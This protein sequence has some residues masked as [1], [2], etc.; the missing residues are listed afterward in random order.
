MR[1]CLVFI[2]QVI[3]FGCFWNKIKARGIVHMEIVGSIKENAV[4]KDTLYS[5]LLNAKICVMMNFIYQF[6]WEMRYRDL[7][8]SGCGEIGVRHSRV[9]E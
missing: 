3:S 1:T 8:L 2:T 5:H 6:A 7:C 4:R 9:S